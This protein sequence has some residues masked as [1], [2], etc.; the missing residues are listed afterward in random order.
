[1]AGP[2]RLVYARLKLGLLDPPGGNPYASIPLSAAN[3]PLHR[4]LAVQTAREV[5]WRPCWRPF[6]LRCTYM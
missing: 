3:S 6:W 2:G 4:A 1:V 5:R